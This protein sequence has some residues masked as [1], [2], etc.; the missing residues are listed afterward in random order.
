[1]VPVVALLRELMGLIVNAKRAAPA[2]GDA[3]RVKRLRVSE[4]RQELSDGGL[5]TDGSRTQ[6]E[7]RL[8]EAVSARGA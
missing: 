3:D 1:M 2:H 6:L 8:R 4:L 5:D 7:E